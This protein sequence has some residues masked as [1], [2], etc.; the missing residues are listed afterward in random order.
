MHVFFLIFIPQAAFSPPVS[1]HLRVGMERLFFIS[2]IHSAGCIAGAARRGTDL[3][4]GYLDAV[5]NFED[6]SN[7]LFTSVSFLQHGGGICCFIS[8][9]ASKTH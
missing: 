2:S 7:M 9:I 5:R 3:L 6:L 4:Q 1:L 8:C